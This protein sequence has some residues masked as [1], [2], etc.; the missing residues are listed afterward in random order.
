MIRKRCTDILKSNR[1]AYPKLAPLILY[2][3]PQAPTHSD[4]YLQLQKVLSTWTATP[5]LR[6][7]DTSPAIL[8]Q[9]RSGICIRAPSSRYSPL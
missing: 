5:D 8:L 6:I 1:I 9:W 2:S 3:F 7:S 4:T